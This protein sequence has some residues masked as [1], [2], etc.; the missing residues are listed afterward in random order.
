ML[1]SVHPRQVLLKPRTRPIDASWKK[2]SSLVQGRAAVQ[3]EPVLIAAGHPW[4]AKCA[5]CPPRFTTIEVCPK[6]LPAA[7]RQAEAAEG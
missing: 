6:D 3:R 5:H 4:E 2:A 1:A 7:L